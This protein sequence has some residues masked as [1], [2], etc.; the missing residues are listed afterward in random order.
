MTES[1][2]NQQSLK[3]QP[4]LYRPLRRKLCLHFSKFLLIGFFRNLNFHF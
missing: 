3:H 4:S 1:S 2:T